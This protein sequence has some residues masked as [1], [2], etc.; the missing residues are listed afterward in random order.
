MMYKI[1]PLLESTRPARFLLWGPNGTGKTR[2]ASTWPKPMLFLDC[3]DGMESIK[4]RGGISRIGIPI[5]SA[6][7]LRKREGKEA[8]M[9]S[10]TGYPIAIEIINDLHDQLTSGFP[11]ATVVLDSLTSFTDAVT[12]F[13][14][15]LNRSAGIKL[16]PAEIGD[17]ANLINEFLIAL[18]ELPCHIVVTAHD[19]FKAE[20]DAPP[21]KDL[22]AAMTRQLFRLPSAPGNK[23]PFALGRFFDEEWLFETETSLVVINK[24]AQEQTRYFAYTRA[25]GVSPAKSRLDLPGNT[26]CPV[27]WAEYCRL[28][29]ADGRRSTDV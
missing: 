20:P 18:C 29:E 26:I 11:W 13:V 4:D 19:C 6:L 5:E 24:R 3:D 10:P 27:T 9:F 17:S 1:E 12:V 16:G 22:G 23:L 7:R 14:Q 21:A 25:R 8:S 2:A 15:A 28:G